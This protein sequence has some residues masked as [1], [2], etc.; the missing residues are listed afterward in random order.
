MILSSLPLW[1]Y[2]LDE[3]HNAFV[4]DPAAKV[5]SLS[6]VL[7]AFVTTSTTFP[8][9]FLSPKETSCVGVVLRQ[10]NNVFGGIEDSSEHKKYSKLDV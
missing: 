3:N 7:H 8:L 6:F 10:T 4:G 9:N 2:S 5:T 1:L